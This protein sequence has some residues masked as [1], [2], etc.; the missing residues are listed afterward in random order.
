[1]ILSG[2]TRS[3][4]ASCSAGL[5]GRCHIGAAVV[6][7]RRATFAHADRRYPPLKQAYRARGLVRDGRAILPLLG[8]RSV[9]QHRPACPMAVAGAS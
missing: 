3:F 7:R 9:W 1:M 4:D 2:T 6:Q 8:G 5:P